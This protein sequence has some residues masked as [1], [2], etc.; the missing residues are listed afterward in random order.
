MSQG[1]EQK[2][3][4]VTI[5]RDENPQNKELRGLSDVLLGSLGLTGLFVLGAL[6]LGFVMAV[7][8]FR[9]RASKPYDH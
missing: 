7:V 2:P 5:P 1:R 3:I 8:M 4:I 6:V 9:L